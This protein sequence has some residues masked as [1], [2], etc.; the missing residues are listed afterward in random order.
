[1]KGFGAKGFIIFWGAINLFG[2][3]S[4]PAY[5]ES[6]QPESMIVSSISSAA[7]TAQMDKY[8]EIK[9]NQPQAAKTLLTQILQK[10]PHNLIANI[11][12]GYLLL[13]KNELQAAMECFYNVLQLNPY[14]DFI[15]KQITYIQ[16]QMQKKSIN[17]IIHNQNE[18][19][20]SVPAAVIKAQ[21]NKYF[22]LKKIQPQA[23]KIL[24]TQILQEDPDNLTAN[25]E[26]GYLLLN[27]NELK[28]AMMRFYRVLQISPYDAAII[29]QISFIQDRM[30]KK[31]IHNEMEDYYQLKKTHP[32][33]AF[34]LLKTMLKKKPDDPS[35]NAEMGYHLLKEKNPA[36]ALQYF[37]QSLKFAPNNKII[38]EQVKSIELSLKP[39]TIIHN[40]MDDYYQLKKTQPEMAFNVLK[41]MLEKKPDDPIL[42]AEM[43]YH[44]LTEKNPVQ[45]LQYFNKSLKFAPNNKVV[46]DQVK[47]IETSLKTPN[48]VLLSE[49][50][51]LLNQYYELRKTN[52]QAA[53]L[54]LQKLV[55]RYPTNLKGQREMAYSL[56]KDKK[57]ELALQHFLIIERLAPYDYDIK[58]QIGYL[59]GSLD[60][61]V[62]A[63]S[64][65]EKARKTTDTALRLK[66]NQALT[67]LGGM[68][69]KILPKP[70]FI[71]LY[72]YPL[73]YSRFDLAVYP[74]Q[75]R[76]GRTF[77]KRNQWEVYLSN[78]TT[79]D[80]R[81]G[82]AGANALPQIFEDN[83]SVFAFGIRYSPFPI[84]KFPIL[85]GI[86]L[87]VE[88]G[89]AY[90]LVR[91]EPNRRWRYD[92]RG[93]LL[94]WNGWGAAHEY[95]DS[96]TLPFKQ[97]GTI[98]SDTSYFSRYN[99]NII[100]YSSLKE[101]LRI[102]EY[103]TTEINLYVR[104]RGGVDKNKEFFNNFLELG[105]GIE[106]IPNNRYNFS[107]RF[108]SLRGFYL[109]VNSPTPNPY[110]S[111]NNNLLI[112]EYYM[113][114]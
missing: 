33:M 6:E 5:A 57:L 13:N 24:L 20:S 93:G 109:S 58:I 39:T 44:L 67:N 31:T 52:S 19:T 88:S 3:I 7:I 25:K 61:P 16:E 98:Y 37:N 68:Q 59:L 104:G 96:L 110:S 97:I 50:D 60:R 11:E 83:A 105:P 108:E 2:A 18:T 71:D 38:F 43:G 48:A 36:L 34:N 55:S 112:A 95:V 66:A 91:R 87:Y 32:E 78:R 35:L 9:K 72:L 21:I 14:D 76:I 77:G 81:S 63:Y 85:K 102:L 99:D 84:D 41:T 12:L 113:L 23:A 114:F 40:E 46:I 73:Y 4:S 22:E 64:Y 103:Q 65:F 111:Y 92:F 17:T 74:G 79:W 62:E 10:D 26:M 30:Q 47:S 8:F 45:A 80:D 86:K 28:A 15:I 75:G 89:K 101:G 69:T 94:Y 70:W 27:N 100:N 49:T 1:M 107:I 42:N 82:Q 106:Y 54:I 56:L 53:K 90:D 29:N 51:K